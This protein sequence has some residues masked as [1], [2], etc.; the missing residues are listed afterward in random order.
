M[1]KRCVFLMSCW[2]VGLVHAAHVPAELLYQGQPIDPLCFGELAATHVRVD[3]KKC[4]I[5]AQV[6]GKKLAGYPPLLAK[7]FV[8]Y[9]YTYKIND[10][11]D[12]HGYSYYNVLSRKNNSFVI[13]TINNGGGTGDLSSLSVVTRQGDALNITVLNAGDRCNHG[14]ERITHKQGNG[15]DDLI[16]SVKLTSYDVLMMADPTLPIKA[17]DDLEDCAICCKAMAV[18]QRPMH[19]DLSQEQLLYINFN[20]FPQEANNATSPQKYQT[21]FNN[22][23]LSYLNI[24]KKT[25]NRAQLAEFARAFKRQCME[26]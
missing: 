21:C 3:L 18:Y 20:A 17:F 23:F 2:V 22:L 10:S 13:Q 1:L 8:G 16:Y 26:S 4:G 15:V 19:K 9:N 7:G 6:K 12:L 14:I 24:G 11:V 25:L 5:H